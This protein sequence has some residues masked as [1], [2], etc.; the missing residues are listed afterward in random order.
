[1]PRAITQFLIVALQRWQHEQLSE[2]S[3]RVPWQP[4]RNRSSDTK[5]RQIYC[6]KQTQCAKPG[7]K[8]CPFQ[9]RQSQVAGQDT[10]QFKKHRQKPL[11]VILVQVCKL[12][13]WRIWEITVCLVLEWV[14]MVTLTTVLTCVQKRKNKERS[15]KGAGFQGKRAWLAHLRVC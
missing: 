4:C 1:M 5:Q 13:Q 7:D 11:R 6:S 15:R 2:C 8:R 10:E 3:G 9:C 12:S 14:C